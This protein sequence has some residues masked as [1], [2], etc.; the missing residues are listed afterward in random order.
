MVYA[1][2]Q[3]P[4]FTLKSRDNPKLDKFQGIKSIICGSESGLTNMPKSGDEYFM[5]RYIFVTGGVVSGIGKGIT[6][7][8][9]GLLL[10][11]SGLSV[12]VI[13]FDPYLN[14]DPGTMS[15][16][17]HGEVYVLKDGSETDLDLGHYERFLDVDLTG[18][19]SVTAGK[20]YAGILDRER[21]GQFLGKNVQIIPH[22]TNYIKDCFTRQAGT[23][24]RIIEIGGSSGDLEAEVFLEGFRQ[25]K[26]ENKDRV[27]H[28]HLGYVPFLACSGEYKT[29]PMQVSMRELSR[30]GLQPD[31]YVLRSEATQARPLPSGI[32]EKIALFGNVPV[33]Q[34]L[35]LPDQDSIYAVPL[36]LLHTKLAS[37]L[38][39]FLG[40][41]LQP[42]LP[43][44]FRN[45]LAFD[46]DT[47]T[48]HIGLVAKYTKLSDAY[49]SVI[50]SVKIAAAKEGYRSK[51][52]LLDSENPDL[53]SE[54]A[55]V[56]GIIV[57]GGFGNRG[58]EGKIRAI[59][60]ARTQNKPFLGICLGMQLAVIEFARNVGGIES[61]VSSEMFETR[62]DLLGKEVVIDYIP[63]QL[64][65]H[66]KGGTMRLGD[67][68]CRLQSG[69][70]IREL[71]G[72]DTTVERHR[73]RLEV[74]QNYLPKLQ[75]HGL[76]VSGKHFLNQEEYLV[77][78]I[79]LSPK[80][81][82]Y[83]VAT[84]SHPEF[85]SRPSRPHPLFVG[86]VR[87]CKPS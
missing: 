6:A 50:E 25:F 87:A 13:K 30:L 18:I 33:N 67:Y 48:L 35:S 70:L 42:K 44:F 17:E 84:Q 85:L 10:K 21:Q 78:M 73:H 74:Q 43:D 62:D 20:I 11:S 2:P 75:Q 37:S 32:L 54:L 51:I 29:K 12:D 47:P 40:R 81:H 55:K 69:T 36:Y 7:A 79:E 24:V 5:T 14:M 58:M 1:W 16:Y 46:Q 76:V 61:A 38:E 66:R 9:L 45:I 26:Q 86:L 39:S 53:E 64:Q 72:V 8:S 82:P 57:P 59:R 34:V 41:E 4:I 22:V 56:D 65:I 60:Y 68:E 28:V 27:L 63:S 49:L 52:K 71:Y 19:S 3:Y 80:D 31:I 23:E 83:F 15:P 77:E